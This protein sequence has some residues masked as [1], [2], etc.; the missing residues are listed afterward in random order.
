MNVGSV[1][2]GTAVVVAVAVGLTGCQTSN[3]YARIGQGPELEYALAKCE[4]DATSTEQGMFAMGSA[5]YVF[6]AQL[7]NAIGNEIRRQE[8]IKRCMILNG[9][10]QGAVPIARAAPPRYRV[11]QSQ[12]PYGR[13]VSRPPTTLVAGQ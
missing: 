9:W 10:R 6:G 4:I 5:G 7:G 3:S 1:A 8:F 13:M 12:A 11:P 2:L